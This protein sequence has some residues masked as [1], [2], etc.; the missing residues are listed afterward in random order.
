MMLHPA[1]P[2]LA[3]L[4]MLLTLLLPRPPGAL[5]RLRL[6]GPAPDQRYWPGPETPAQHTAPPLRELALQTR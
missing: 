5:P 1:S 4:F 6:A 3:V 2:A